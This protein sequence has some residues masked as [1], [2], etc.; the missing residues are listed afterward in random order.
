MYTSHTHFCISQ[1][2]FTLLYIHAF[3]VHVTYVRKTYAHEHGV[4]YHIRCI[5]PKWIRHICMYV[6]HKTVLHCYT[7]THRTYTSHMLA[8]HMHIDTVFLYHNR[9]IQL[10]CTRMYVSHKTVLNCYTYTHLMYTTHMLAGHTHTNM[11]F[12]SY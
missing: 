10:K 7:Y 4:L 2:S 12:V 6:F 8:R 3:N 5:Q 11:F 1:N 9:Y